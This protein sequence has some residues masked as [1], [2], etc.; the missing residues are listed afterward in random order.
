VRLAAVWGERGAWPSNRFVSTPLATVVRRRLKHQACPV[1]A[2][3]WGFLIACLHACMLALIDCRDG[4]LAKRKGVGEAGCTCPGT[5]L[6]P[7][8]RRRKLTIANRNGRIHGQDE[9]R[10]LLASTVAAVG[11]ARGPVST[12][13]LTR[14]HHVGTPT[15]TASPRTLHASRSIAQPSMA[16]HSPCSW[17][18][19]TSARFGYR[20]SACSSR[21]PIHAFKKLL[22]LKRTSVGYSYDRGA[23]S[24]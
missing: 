3:P 24:T 13:L 5:Y 4:C 16:S 11:A 21:K 2:R 12:A 19:Y 22:P 18:A 20:K 23:Q 15:P 6:R 17:S 10:N 8:H 1:A 14:N 9:S 7:R